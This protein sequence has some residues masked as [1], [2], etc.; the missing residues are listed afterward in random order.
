MLFTI[1]TQELQ[2]ELKSNLAQIRFLLKKNPALGY[3][4][5]NEISR[6]VGQK[7]GLKLILNFP[8]QG[9]IEETEFY[10]KRDV[11][12][13]IDLQRKNFPID[14][15]IIK[16]KAQEIFVNVEA[17]DAYMY[18][19]KEGVRVLFERGRIDVLPHSLHIWCEFKDDVTKFCDWLLENV[20][21]LKP[22][23]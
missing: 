5:M 3:T 2:K 1:I 10:G 4:K 13:I 9:K 22:S 20:Y 7:F 18:E 19:D 21:Q 16:S 17:V 11:S 8:K 23:N 15:S 12:I 14:R 6:V